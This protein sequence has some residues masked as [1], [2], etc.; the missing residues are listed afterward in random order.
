LGLALL[1]FAAG[2]DLSP[3]EEPAPPPPPPPPCADVYDNAVNT[4]VA[5]SG[6]AGF[7][8]FYVWEQCSA[9]AKRGPLL[10]CCVANYQSQVD[11]QSCIDS[12]GQEPSVA[13]AR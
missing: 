11:R 7:A 8:C 12:L 6:C 13:A 9:D 1:L 5:A 2:C 10:D 4:C 3:S